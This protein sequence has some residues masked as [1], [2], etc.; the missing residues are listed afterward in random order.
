MNTYTKKE[1]TLYCVDYLKR[2][3]K[4]T[5]KEI[6]TDLMIELMSKSYLDSNVELTKEVINKYLFVLND[7]GTKNVNKVIFEFLKALKIDMQDI[8]FDKVHITGLN[9]SGLKNVNIN[10]DEIPNKDLSNVDFNGVILTGSLDN[11]SIYYTSFNGY[12]GFLTLNPQNVSYKKLNG[13]KLDGIIVDGVFDDVDIDYVNFKGAKGACINPQTI[14]NKTLFG[15]NL[16]GVTLIGNYNEEKQTYEEASFEG[17]GIFNTSFKNAK[18]NIYINLDTLS[19]IPVVK[20]SCCD[21]T[22]VTILGTARCYTGKQDCVKEDGSIIM[23]A[24]KND[25]YGSYYTYSNNKIVKIGL[26][27]SRVWDDDTKKFKF[28]KREDEPSLKFKTEYIGLDKVKEKEKKKL[29]KRIL[30]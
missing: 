20:L 11:A 26:Y 16:D 5:N 6:V 7:D 23:D 12:K 15:V 30:K 13:A 1:F 3:Q 9:F 18:G 4:N 29:W 2:C 10:L 17:C 25:L 19:S 27:R 21:L 28:L 14:R 22:N 8:S 24:S